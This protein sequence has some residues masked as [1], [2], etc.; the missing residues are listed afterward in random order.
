MKAVEFFFRSLT[1]GCF[2]S[3]LIFGKWCGSA[4]FWDVE[5]DSLSFEA[6]FSNF[7]DGDDDKTREPTFYK[8]CCFLGEF[9]REKNDF[10]PRSVFCSCFL[11]DISSQGLCVSSFYFCFSIFGAF[12]SSFL[13]LL[14][15]L[16]FLSV[17]GLY[18]ISIVLVSFCC[19]G[20]K[21]G[22]YLFGGG[23]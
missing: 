4:S 5:D 17:C 16:C 20:S 19:T 18:P 2:G 10:E 22:L 9:S 21:L 7:F 15:E 14:R 12:D 13:I 23:A 6:L 1:F 11:G 8:R 3:V